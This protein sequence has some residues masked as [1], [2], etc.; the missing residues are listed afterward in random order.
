MVNPNKP[1]KVR[2]VANA[3][4]KFRGQSLNSILIT[5]PDLLNNL[6]G[7]L[8]SF[9][10]NPVAI[11]SDIEG[12]LMQIAI[13][14]EDQSALRFLWPN[15]EMVNQYQFTRLI[16]EA[17]CSP[18]CA[19]FVLN[20]CAEDKAVEFPKAVKAIKNHF[21]MDDYIHSLTSI[22]ETIETFNQTKN[23]LHKGGF[24]L[25]KFVSNKHEA[26]RFIDQ[27]GRDQLKEINRVFGQKWNMRPD[28]F[29][30]NTLEQFPRNESE[31]T[32]RKM[33]SSVSTIFG[34]LEILSPLT[35]RIKMLLQ[36][37]WKPGKK[38]DEPLPAEL[39]SN[40]QKVLD[41]YFAMPVIKIHRF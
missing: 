20:R 1:G 36:Q 30:M 6:V 3:A 25:T 16:F 21:Y 32:K 41:S 2:R 29:L 38:R 31:Y 26:Q 7:I 40:L 27:E 39:H 15:E 18:F 24:R 22:E 19:I 4:A 13:R 9:R 17:T 8:L 14:H 34:P 28:C 12:M 11:L 33:F 23:S 10:E 5:R 35:I 37:V